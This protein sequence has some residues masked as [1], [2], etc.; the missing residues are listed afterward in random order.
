MQRRRRSRQP[1][2]AHHRP[3]DRHQKA[4]A[5]G[6]LEKAAKELKLE[7]KKTEP[8]FARGTSLPGVGG[9]SAIDAAVF[10]APVGS[11][12]QAAAGDGGAIIAKIQA[13]SQADMSQLPAEEGFIREA[14]QRPLGQQVIAKR[15]EEL[16]RAAKIELN[17]TLFQR[18]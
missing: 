15:I 3:S 9:G 14:L 1:G 13:R 7:V 17:T 6:D 10:N 16:R 12:S 11:V 18:S 2:Q 8:A 5:G 4:R